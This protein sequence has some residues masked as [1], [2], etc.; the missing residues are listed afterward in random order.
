MHDLLIRNARIVDG[1]GGP[2][3]HGAV[4]VSD[5]RVTE[6]GD[7][8]GLARRIVDAEGLVVAPGFVDIHTHYDAQLAWDPLCTP[9]LLPRD[10]EHRD[11]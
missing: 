2:S 8:N 10:D 6:T 1:S 3:R 11:E 5:G 9:L 7:V 4:A